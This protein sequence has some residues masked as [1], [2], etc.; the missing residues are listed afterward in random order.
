MTSLTKAPDEVRALSEDNRK[1]LRRWLHAH[2]NAWSGWSTWQASEYAEVQERWDRLHAA[3]CPS[4]A[5]THTALVTA[6]HDAI[7]DLRVAYRR[8][9]TK[10]IVE[11]KQ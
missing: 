9:Y 10:A 3:G 7:A 1:L 4:Y 2:P 11:G 8:A 5:G 6:A